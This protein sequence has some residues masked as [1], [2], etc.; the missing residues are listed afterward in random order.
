ML[1]PNSSKKIMLEHPW[2]SFLGFVGEPSLVSKTPISRGVTDELLIRANLTLAKP[3]TRG[4]E[5]WP[6]HRIA[7][8]FSSFP[9]GIFRRIAF[10]INIF[11]VI[12]FN[13]TFCI[14]RHASVQ[15]P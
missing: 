9:E 14:N 15:R 8:W 10:H 3:A 7:L 12:H 11:G 5:K 2:P 6:S 1:N 4:S 13:S